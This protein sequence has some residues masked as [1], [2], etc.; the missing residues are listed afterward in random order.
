MSDSRHSGAT[1]VESLVST[2]LS[3]NTS[4][5]NASRA[6]VQLRASYRSWDEVADADVEELEAVIRTA[7]LARQKSRTISSAL[8][9]I[10]ER[11]GG[12]EPLGVDAIDDDTLLAELTAMQGI[13]LKTA[14]CV[15]MFSLGRDLCAVDTHIHR[16]VNRIGL[17]DTSSADRTFHELRPLIPVGQGLAL[18][19]ALIRFGRHVCKSQRPHCFEC[20]LFDLCA[21]SEKNRFAAEARPG[22]RA[23]SGDMVLS[24]VMALGRRDHNV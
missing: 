6:Y 14:A 15:L 7:G 10:R 11:N 13:G 3:Q 23:V 22:P 1:F 24:D 9:T 21:W 5:V 8:R 20:P 4:D 19:V 12:F 16:V 17:V 18:H 2:I